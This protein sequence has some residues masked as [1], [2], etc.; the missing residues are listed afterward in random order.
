VTHSDLQGFAEFDGA[1]WTYHGG[2]SQFGDMLEDFAGNVW[3]TTGPSG[4]GVWKWNGA[5]YTSWLGLGGTSTVTGLGIGLDGTVYVSTWYGNIYK[6]IG[7]TTPVFFVNAD[8]IPGSVY[9]RPD[10]DIWINNYGGNG[11]LGTVRH[12]TSNGV[13][14]ERINTYNSGL[15]WYFIDKI[16]T[17]SAGNLWFA[18][19]EGGLSRMLGSDGAADAPTRWRNW[20]NHNDLSEPYPF[21]GNEPMYSMYEHPD[22]TIYMGGNGIA[23]WDPATGQ[24][25]N[26]WNW[27]NSNLGVDSFIA[28]EQDGNGDLWIASDY[29]G[30]YK[31][32]EDNWEQHLFG[33]P[34]TTANYVRDMVRDTDG[35][36]WVATLTSLHFFNGTNWFAV[37][38]IHGSPVEQ[39]QRL[40]ADPAGGIWIGAS[41]GLIHYADAQ[42]QV[43]DPSNS[44]MPA[45]SVQGLD[46]RADGLLGMAVADFGPVTPFP[47]GV[48]LFDGTE[49][50]VYSYGTDPLPHYQLG[51]VE[52]DADGD[53]WVSTTSE[54]VT[55]IV[56]GAPALPADFDG[57][58]DVD[59][60][61]FLQLLGSW[62]PCP[63]APGCTGDVNG[64][65][66]VDVVDMLLLLAS[67]T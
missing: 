64:D 58:G 30:L 51:D 55:E 16:Q 11:T 56:L 13:L 10:G 6:M 22:G 65:G 37:G 49:W 66:S 4:A 43:Y 5:S 53:L 36:L 60:T 48:V 39:P 15:P 18:C 61:D 17:D 59:V 47:N 42:W 50:Q 57:D 67:W 62:G 12:Y 40:A 54:G 45:T 35:N 28:I 26:F 29:T 31:L 8:N 1:S 20:G 9:Q 14:L 19:G 24:F 38:P 63:G 3:F 52:F 23:Q 33:V 34:F 2:G 46:I 25:L 41:N 21:A 32:A 27:Q 7:G 44:P